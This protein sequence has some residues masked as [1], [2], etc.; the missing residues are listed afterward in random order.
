MHAQPIPRASGG[1]FGPQRLIPSMATDADM[2][3]AYSGQTVPQPER[4]WQLPEVSPEAD[5]GPPDH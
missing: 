4:A 3:A 1:P 2:L 5:A